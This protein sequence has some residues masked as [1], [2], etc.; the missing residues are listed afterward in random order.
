MLVV[1]VLHHPPHLALALG[2]PL[3]L[4]LADQCWAI[5]S[6]IVHRCFGRAIARQ[7][8]LSCIGSES[9]LLQL[10]LASKST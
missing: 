8:Q 5:E 4:Q 9:E 6:T 7:R 1:V 10:N 3:L 2:P